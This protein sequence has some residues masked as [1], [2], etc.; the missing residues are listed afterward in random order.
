MMNKRAIT[1]ILLIA[2]LLPGPAFAGRGGFG[3]GGRGG[4]GGFSRGGFDMHSDVPSSRPQNMSHSSTGPAGTNR[5]TNVQQGA[6]GGYARET[7]ATNGDASRTSYGGASSNGN[8][9]HGSTGSTPYGTHTSNTTGNV[10]SGNF[11]HTGSGSNQYGAYS[12][13]GSGNTHNGTY[14]GSAVGVN[15]WGQV[16]TRNTSAANG[17]VYHGATVTNPVYASYGAWG[18]NGGYAW[19]PA[20]SYWGGGFWGPFAV[21]AAT[22]VVFGSIAYDNQTYQSYQ[23]QQSS[24]GAKLLS[25]Y[26]LTQVPC[27]PSGLVV[28]FGPNNSVICAKPNQYVAAGNYSINSSTL[29]LVSEKG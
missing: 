29:T 27:E 12:T 17:V 13:S 6:N 15:S 4:G 26:Q 1:A 8:Y 22:A 10:N 3:G 28:I 19:Y 24:A 25:A 2:A 14:N 5:T 20:P 11:Q 7:T 9:T 16:Y 23:V 18:W 21:G